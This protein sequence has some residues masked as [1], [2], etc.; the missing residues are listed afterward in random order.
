MTLIVRNITE[1]DD[2]ISTLII[3]GYSDSEI[4]ELTKQFNNDMSEIKSID[5]L[6]SCKRLEMSQCLSQEWIVSRLKRLAEGQDAVAA[7]EALKTLS[8]MSG[9]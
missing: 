2:V 8:G 6:I 3:D 4:Q 5:Y 9:R 1:L 7:V